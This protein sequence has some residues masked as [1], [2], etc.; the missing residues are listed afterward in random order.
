MPHRTAEER[1]TYS[2]LWRARN[3]ERVLA[4]RRRYYTEN[5]ELIKKKARDYTREN[6]EWI[7]QRNRE[8][9][10]KHLQE[11]RAREKQRLVTNPESY[12]FYSAKMRAKKRG[13]PFTLV[14]D[15]II[16]PSHCP[17]FGSPLTRGDGK[18]RTNSP[19]IDRIDNNKGY[20][21]DNIIVVSFRA[22]NLKS[23]ASL[24]ELRRL[25]AYYETR[26]P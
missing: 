25:V 1:A 23:D 2:K 22:N 7:C 13:I 11:I 19:S 6:K 20:T 18:F 4:N 24:D 16:I 3:K 9:R 15:D 5:K 8:F 10:Q 17:V 12:L 21:K 26:L 14:L